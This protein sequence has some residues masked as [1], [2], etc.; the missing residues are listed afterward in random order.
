V[1]GIGYFGR[2][3]YIG[4]FVVGIGYRYKI[5]VYIYISSDIGIWGIFGQKNAP[6]DLAML[7]YGHLEN[8]NFYSD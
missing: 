4:N 6:D 5:Y 3:F 1:A 2:N 7:Y 8:V